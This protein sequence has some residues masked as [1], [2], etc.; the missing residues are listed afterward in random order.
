M[1]KWE[2][3]K[4]GE[5]YDFTRGL[6]YSKK[7][8]VE[9]SSNCILRSNNIDLQTNSINLDELKYIKD[10]IAIPQEKYVRK[11][12]ILICM[13]NGSK[14]HLGKV[15]Y[16]DKDYDFAFGG[17]MGLLKPKCEINGKFVHLYLCSDEYKNFIK[18]LSDGANINNL[19]FD[20]LRKFE[21][22][23][24]PLSEQKRIVKFLDEEFSK[25]ETLKT[26]AETNLKN[27]KEL[28]ET[29]LEKELNPPSRHSERSEESSAEL[30]SGW[31][32][33]KMED[34]C[35]ITSSKRVYQSEWQNKG[36]PFLRISD[37]V[38]LFENKKEI[39]AELFISPEKYNELKMN[40]QVPEAGDILITARGTLGT[41]YIVKPND[42]FYFQDGMITWLKNIS[43]N[44]H[45]S[46]ITYL[47]KNSTF[48][49]QIDKNQ[50][51]STVAY[52]SISMLKKFVLPLP[53][54]SVQKEI[55]ARLDKL[56]EDVKRLEANYKQ[57]IANCDELK[58]TTLKQ[59]FQGGN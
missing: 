30:P 54:L 46:F 31:E 50:L 1:S 6:T 34:I 55:V 47:F 18:S 27:A 56:S 11:N 17:F 19:K 13:S 7:D 49:R 22:P 12:T 5:V 21:I 32:W 36:I 8:E 42:C 37:F 29:T 58:K 43:N 33:K 45:P 35:E 24:P 28:F 48:R 20:D 44:I 16:I 23:F 39:D 52:L 4:L 41:C 57:I 26:N 59:T 40:N 9:S 51:G 10:E 3:K 15:A 2:W 53:P 38:Q 25:I 14:A